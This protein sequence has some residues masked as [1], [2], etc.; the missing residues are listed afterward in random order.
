MNRQ[1]PPVA[2]AHLDGEAQ[3]EVT[4][5]CVQSALLLLQYGAESN[6]VVGVSTRLG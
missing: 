3:H 1:T 6:L 5:L 4:R 2:A